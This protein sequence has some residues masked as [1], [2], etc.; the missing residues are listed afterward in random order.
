MEASGERNSS[1]SGSKNNERVGQKRKIE[2]QVTFP[3]SMATA[4]KVSRRPRKRL[5]PGTR[6]TLHDS[7]S[8][9]Y[10]WLLAGWLCEERVMESGRV[11]RYFY[12]P[13]GTL[14]NTQQEVKAAWEKNKLFVLE[15]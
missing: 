11:Y 4:E 2:W 10:G 9:G 3:T 5:Q 6:I 13:D 8:P 7:S 14:Y 12:D 15:K 1:S